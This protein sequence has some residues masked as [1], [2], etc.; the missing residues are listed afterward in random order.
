MGKHPTFLLRHLSHLGNNQVSIFSDQDTRNFICIFISISIC[1]SISISISIS[2]PSEPRCVS[3]LRSLESPPLHRLIG[4]RV[5]RDRA[6]LFRSPREARPPLCGAQR[7]N[8]MISVSLSLSLSLNSFACFVMGTATKISFPNANN[9][10][11]E[12]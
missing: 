9:R 8:G 11:R 10:Y 12:E 4:R 5:H 3:C 2:A 1:I 6:C 7:K